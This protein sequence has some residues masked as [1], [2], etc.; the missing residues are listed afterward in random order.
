M[1]SKEELNGVWSDEVCQAWLD[2]TLEYCRAAGFS[3]EDLDTYF[4][5][6]APTPVLNYLF[7]SM[8]NGGDTRGF[9]LEP[10][11]AE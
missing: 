6:H 8:L 2:H 3:N 9:V 7:I 11:T 10:R 1:T 5:Q 4:Q